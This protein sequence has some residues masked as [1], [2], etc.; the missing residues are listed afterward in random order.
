[1]APK[2]SPY[3]IFLTHYRDYE[4]RKGKKPSS[5]KQLSIELSP[6][7]NKMTD[8]EK[9]KY[10]VLANKCI[11]NTNHSKEQPLSHIS[12][13][14]EIRRAVCNMEKLV[15]EMFEN[16]PN[17]Q[18]LLNKKFIL[19]HV[20]CHSYDEEQYYFPAEIS[21]IEFNLKNGLFRT[22][23]Q[24]IGFSKDKLK[25]YPPPGYPSEMRIFSRQYHQIDCLDKHPD[26][27]QNIFIDFLTFLKNEIINKT[28]VKE[29]KLE[30]PYLFT[31]ESDVD[32][33]NIMKTINSLERLY[34][35]AFPEV[36]TELC[37]SKFKIANAEQLLL[38]MKKK[39][40]L[41]MDD[42]YLEGVLEY[43]YYTQSFCCE[44]HKTT[45]TTNFKCSKSRIIQWMTNICNHLNTYVDLNLVPGRHMAA[46]L[47]DDSLLIIENAHLPLTSA[48]LKLSKNGS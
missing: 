15:A 6:I 45:C 33:N 4:I 24:I 32:E 46:I 5:Y 23:H 25:A 14:D 16:I 13:S 21:A 31:V 27:Y 35:S 37:K 20:N 9:N 48:E 47:K 10:K 18:E 26:D 44:Y 12:N 30:L 11:S 38:E 28:D 19:L 36:D 41:P 1:M 22:Y 7:W 29:G 34:S 43:E 42:D 17:D 2:K 40:N 8:A 39:M 3:F